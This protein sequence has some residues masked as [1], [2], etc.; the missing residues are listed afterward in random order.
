M[1]VGG[2][3]SNFVLTHTAGVKGSNQGNQ[4]L[5]TGREKVTDIFAGNNNL[6][7]AEVSCAE[8]M[9]TFLKNP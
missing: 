2:E 7:L 3:R 8:N 5:M 6:V 9:S 1:D 4:I